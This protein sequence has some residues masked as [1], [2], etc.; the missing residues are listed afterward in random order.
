MHNGELEYHLDILRGKNYPL[1]VSIS[2]AE[3]L[4]ECFRRI[5]EMVPQDDRI[6]VRADYDAATSALLHP[7]ETDYTD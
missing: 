1:I 4:V 5:M 7:T 2:A 6:Y 3:A